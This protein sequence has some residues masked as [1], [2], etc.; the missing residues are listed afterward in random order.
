MIGQLLEMAPYSWWFSWRFLK[1]QRARFDMLPV[2]LGSESL[3]TRNIRQNKR[4]NTAQHG[5]R[6]R[7]KTNISTEANTPSSGASKP[8][9]ARIKRE[10]ER[11]R[12]RIFSG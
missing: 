7:M 6:A 10:R 2:V 11:E 8:C 1:S 5:Q 3:W 4:K 12:E 9:A